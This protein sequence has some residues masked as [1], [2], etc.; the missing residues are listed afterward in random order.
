[1]DRR[2]K[3]PQS[4]PPISPKQTPTPQT[5]S[6]YQPPPL[7]QQNY[8]RGGGGGGRGYGQN[9]NQ[10]DRNHNPNQGDRHQNSNQGDRN[11]NFNRG[12]RNQGGG[13]N[14]SQQGRGR[15]GPNGSITCEA[16]GRIN[17]LHW[18]VECRALLAGN[19]WANPNHETVKWR[20][21]PEG[22][23]ALEHGYDFVPPPTKSKRDESVIEHGIDTQ[24]EFSRL[25]QLGNECIAKIFTPPYSLNPTLPK[26]KWLELKAL[27]DT[28]ADLNFISCRVAEE[29]IKKGIGFRGKGKYRIIDAFK[30]TRLFYEHLNFKFTMS[31]FKSG[32]KK[33]MLIKAVIIDIPFLSDVIIGLRTIKKFRLFR[34]LPSLVEDESEDEESDSEDLDEIDPDIHVDIDLNPY[35]ISQ[36]SKI[37]HIKQFK[38]MFRS[39]ST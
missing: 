38:P 25:N 5:T 31:D 28:G 4:N 34:N 26:Q 14:S 22:R 30:E 27:L 3:Y 16:C 19:R 17:S 6:P 23:A 33:T 7:S 9:S 37:L 13:R 11:Q 18:A 39:M 35:T 32:N 20:D 21:S 2:E 29:L 8:L 1:M 24:F 12:D 36:G 10:G 15:G